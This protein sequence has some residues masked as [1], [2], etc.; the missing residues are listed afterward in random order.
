MVNHW[1]LRTLVS[2]AS[3]SLVAALI[4]SL[5]TG[6]GGMASSAPAAQPSTSPPPSTPQRRVGQVAVP[7][8]HNDNARSGINSSETILSPKTV[9]PM[10]FGKVASL[11]VQ[12]YIYAQP[13]YVP[14]LDMGAQGLHNTVIVATEHD[15]LYAFDVDSK[16]PLWHTDFLGSSGSVS[17]L[18]V[19][20]LGGC[21]DLIPEVG[22][23]G[24]PVIDL[25]KDALY[26]VVRTKE[27]T[28]AGPAFYQRLHAIDL[29]TGLDLVAPTLITSPPDGY[30]ATGEAKFDPLLNNQRSALL[31][32]NG[33]VYVTW[34]SHCDFGNYQGWLMSFDENSLQATAWWTPA[35][36]SNWGGIWMSGGGPS[37]DATGDVYVAVGNGAGMDNIGVEDNY[38]SSLVRLRW[39]STEGF[40]LVDYFS[41]YNHQILDD[42]DE[43]FGTSSPVLLPAQPGAPH[44]NL[45]IVGSKKGT[46][47]LLDRDNPGKWH[48]GDDSQ[49]VQSY[50]TPGSGFSTPVFWKNTLYFAANHDTLKAYAFNSV[51]QQF[52]PNWSS[53][54]TYQLGGR[55]ATPSLSSNGVVNGLVW[56]ISDYAAGQHAVLHALDASDVSHEVYSSAFSPSRDGAGL[57]VKFSTPTIAD[58]LV[59]VGAQ[60]ELDVYGLLGQ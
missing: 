40:T 5:L 54:A 37:T 1:K 51:Q 19:D 39:S 50:Q 57:G 52:N 21:Q 9:N 45:L 49:I 32:A 8:Y 18:S 2:Y 11:A 35:P 58:G 34:A 56:I 44:P 53:S 12:G 33:Q 46:L 26:V 20:D 25:Q 31:L 4:L 3:R 7:T 23:T 55:G 22:I 29:V 28:D 47:Y 16:Q 6:C 14:N 60:N 10:G 24:T 38:R 36:H 27:T 41:P 17:T 48:V 13:L 43:D 15:Q 30:T 59:F 42:M